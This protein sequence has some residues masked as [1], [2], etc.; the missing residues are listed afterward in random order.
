MEADWTDAAQ[1]KLVNTPTT[2]RKRPLADALAT[3]TGGGGSDE[4]GD[5]QQLLRGPEDTDGGDTTDAPSTKRVRREL[6]RRNTLEYIPL[7]EEQRQLA[8]SAAGDST[9]QFRPLDGYTPPPRPSPALLL[10]LLL[11]LSVPPWRRSIIMI[12]RAWC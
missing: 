9:E 5:E 6:R 12:M 1:A 3:T 7:T 10:L 8:A 11:Q 2:P 4:R